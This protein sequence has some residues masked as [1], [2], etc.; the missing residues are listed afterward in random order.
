MTE[1][2]AINEIEIELVRRDRNLT[3]SL[4]GGQS[5]ALLSPDEARR[6]AFALAEIAQ[7][8]DDL[9]DQT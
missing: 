5:C 2:A 9:K 6:L 4:P 8:A 7:A 1:N 3:L